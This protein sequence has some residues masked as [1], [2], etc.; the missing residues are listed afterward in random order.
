MKLR[1]LLIITLLILALSQPS[2]KVRIMANEATIYAD[3]IYT[4]Y[5]KGGS[6]YENYIDAANRAELLNRLNN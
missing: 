1:T 2:R 6:T 3:S 4:D 5:L